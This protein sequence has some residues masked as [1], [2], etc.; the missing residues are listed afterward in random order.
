MVVRRVGLHQIRGAAVDLAVSAAAKLIADQVDEAKSAT[1]IDEAIA[2]LP[3]R[4]H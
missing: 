4:L 2:D 1:L 3:K